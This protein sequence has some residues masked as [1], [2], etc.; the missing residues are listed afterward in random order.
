MNRAK[1][2]MAKS[3]QKGTKIPNSFD[4]NERN[5]RA[6]SVLNTEKALVVEQNNV[7]RKV[8]HLEHVSSGFLRFGLLDFQGVNPLTQK[9]KLYQTLLTAMRKLG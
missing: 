2:V 1:P 3:K 9:P 6:I 7:C 8:P 5:L 4:N